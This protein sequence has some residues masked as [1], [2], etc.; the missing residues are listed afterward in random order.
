M[1]LLL[2]C[3]D[4][5]HAAGRAPRSAGRT[6][7]ASRMRATETPRTICHHRL[8]AVLLRHTDVARCWC[9]C[10]CGPAAHGRPL[11]GPLMDCSSGRAGE[12]DVVDCSLMLN[13]L[14]RSIVTCSISSRSCSTYVLLN[15]LLSAM[16]M[17]AMSAMRALRPTLT[18]V[19]RSSASALRVHRVVAAAAPARRISGTA[20]LRAEGESPGCASARRAAGSAAH[21]C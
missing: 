9:R 11:V 19:P 4:G 6:G 1:F 10:R 21:R 14:N 7:C 13:S 16:A 5:V 18:A 2:K 8:V 12:L 17:S 15:A 20:A 3:R